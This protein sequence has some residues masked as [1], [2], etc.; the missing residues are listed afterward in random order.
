METWL[1][2]TGAEDALTEVFVPSGSE[3]TPTSGCSRRATLRPA[4]RSFA[5]WLPVRGPPG[6]TRGGVP[7]ATGDA[8]EISAPWAG[9]SLRRRSPKRR[10]VH[11]RRATGPSTEAESMTPTTSRPG[12]L[13]RGWVDQATAVAVHPRDRSGGAT[14]DLSL[15]EGRPPPSTMGHARL[16][17]TV[18]FRSAWRSR[19]LT[20]ASGDTTR[21]S[22]GPD[23]ER[24]A[25]PPD[26]LDQPG[27][28]LRIIEETLALK[29]DLLTRSRSV[30]TDWA[31]EPVVIQAHTQ[32]LPST[33]RG[34]PHSWIRR[35]PL[36][37]PAHAAAQQRGLLSTTRWQRSSL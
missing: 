32:C 34:D 24:R 11:P 3:S 6:T 22:R 13:P 16:P 23:D 21:A 31:R 14:T 15:L 18:D 30:N 9:L 4:S 12:V 29:K 2:L 5:A 19:F 27:P 33:D 10:T 20:C 8:Y 35:P 1:P 7:T 37:S 28:R 17:D 26:G 36:Y 25:E